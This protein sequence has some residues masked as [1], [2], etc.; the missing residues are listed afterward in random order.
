MLMALQSR[1]LP[2]PALLLLLQRLPVL[3][4]GLLGRLAAQLLPHLLGQRPRWLSRRGRRLNRDRQWRQVGVLPVRLRL[5][6]RQLDLPGALLLHLGF[7]LRRRQPGTLRTVPPLANVRE[8][9][10][11]TSRQGQVHLVKAAIIVLA[12]ARNCCY[13]RSSTEAMHSEEINDD[14]GRLQIL[15]MC[16]LCHRVQLQ[17]AG[18]VVRQPPFLQASQRH[19][20]QDSRLSSAARCVASCRIT[21]DMS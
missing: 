14:N 12:A 7:V 9:M 18:A 2:L 3:R 4:G 11:R 13:T 6:R 1:L 17:R 15:P 8:R 19:R 20:P 16:D 10:L 21:C 5:L